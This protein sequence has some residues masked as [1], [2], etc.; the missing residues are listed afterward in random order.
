[1]VLYA[2]IHPC[3]NLMERFVRVGML[4]QGAAGDIA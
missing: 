1:M 2:I 3:I 4:M